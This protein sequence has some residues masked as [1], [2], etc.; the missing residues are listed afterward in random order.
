MNS[1]TRGGDG[2]DDLALSATAA[3]INGTEVHA[4]G[5]VGV[6]RSRNAKGRASACIQASGKC[7]GSL[8]LGHDVERSTII[9]DTLLNQEVDAGSS[10]LVRGSGSGSA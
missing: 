10:G 4:G 6:E 7:V 3:L 2:E 1:K 9:V 8:S 5:C